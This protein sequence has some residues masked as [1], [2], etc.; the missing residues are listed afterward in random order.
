MKIPR[1]HKLPTENGYY[2]YYDEIVK[3]FTQKWY[4]GSTSLEFIDL[5][6]TTEKYLVSQTDPEDW[7]VRI[8]IETA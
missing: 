7:S 1:A 8:E 5:H 3:V 2:F 4:D 6:D